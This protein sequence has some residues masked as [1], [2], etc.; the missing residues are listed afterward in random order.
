M[1][2]A[3][4]A[5][6]AVSRVR[7]YLTYLAQGE[8][9]QPHDE[10]MLAAIEEGA[11]RGEPIDGPYEV[12]LMHEL[13]EEGLILEHQVAAHEALIRYHGPFS[14]YAGEV[15]LAY[16]AHFNSNWRNYWEGRC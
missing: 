15:V 13:V 6:A 7:H 2:T 14:N 16:P 8:P 10:A 9:L 4:G 5:R 1:A 3:E 12:Y 11:E